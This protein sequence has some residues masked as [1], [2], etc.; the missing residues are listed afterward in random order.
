MTAKKAFL[1][2]LMLGLTAKA[3]AYA[4]EPVPVSEDPLVHMPDTQPEQGIDLPD[5]GQCFNCH[6][7]YDP[8]A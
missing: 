7:D 2:L 6:A 8:V 4:W 1:F 3:V 5:S